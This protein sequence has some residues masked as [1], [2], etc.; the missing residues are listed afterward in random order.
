MTDS[1]YFDAQSS[2]MPAVGRKELQ[3]IRPRYLR[4]FALAIVLWTSLLAAATLIIDPYGISSIRITIPHINRYKPKRLDIDRLV[5]PYEVW[6]YQPRTIF[7][8]T[9]RIHQSIDPRVLDATG[10]APAYNASVPANTLGMNISYLQ[11]Y[12]KLDPK[13]QNVF[14]ELF[15]YNFLGTDQQHSPPDSLRTMLKNTAPLFW[16]FDGFWDALFTLRYNI[17][18]NKPCYEITPGGY[19]Y[20][21][22]GEPKDTFNGFPAGMLDI[23]RME[24]GNPMLSEPAFT[25]VDELIDTARRHRVNLTFLVT[26]YHPY[27]WY[28][29]ESTGRWGLVADWLNRLTA[30]TPILS[31]A[32]PNAWTYE[33]V[34]RHMT[35]WNDPFHFSLAMGRGIAEALG[36]V[37]DPDV[38][39][40]LMVK[41]TPDRVPQFIASQREAL[42]H[43]AHAH[44]D[45]V[46]AFEA[47]KRKRE[48]ESL[49]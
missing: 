34:Q 42:L 44:P 45:F 26:A 14:I 8:G 24:H 5:K 19:F 41:L 37:Q 11:E 7:L 9:S 40:N 29:I 21:P 10:F 16:S 48:R 31:F 30:I 1:R 22:P 17:A 46:A 13:L 35:Y 38:P 6:R 39:A 32:Q 36:Q 4:H 12:I 27:Y 23:D 25:S 49:R 2:R 3:L 20:Y 47:E 18:V 33:P 43:W 28:Y 15:L